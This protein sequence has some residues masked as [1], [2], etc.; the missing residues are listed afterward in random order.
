MRKLAVLLVICLGAV[1]AGAWA[2]AQLVPVARPLSEWMPGGALMYME[3][4]EFGTQ[5]R[6]WNQSAFK[7]EWLTS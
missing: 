2:T 7:A 3:S 4:S 5:L 6:E 1:I